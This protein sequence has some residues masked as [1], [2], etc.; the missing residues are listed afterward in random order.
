MVIQTREPLLDIYHVINSWYEMGV[1]YDNDSNNKWARDTMIVH[2]E[3]Y[4]TR[5]GLPA[6]I[7]FLPYTFLWQ[8]LLML[9]FISFFVSLCFV[10]TYVASIRIGYLFCTAAMI[11]F[12]LSWPDKRLEPMIMTLLKIVIISFLPLFYSFFKNFC[13][14]IYYYFKIN[15]LSKE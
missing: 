12:C 4:K 2:K 15:L 10:T 9:V 1:P 6:F 7:T 3:D 8:D 5:I 14:K 13:V 11:F